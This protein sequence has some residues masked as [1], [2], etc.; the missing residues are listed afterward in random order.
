MYITRVSTVFLCGRRPSD[1]Y[2]GTWW[3]SG[4]TGSQKIQIGIIF[5]WRKKQISRFHFWITK[6][7]ILGIRSVTQ[8]DGRA[9][10]AWKW[11][12]DSLK[13]QWTRK[14]RNCL[15]SWSPRTR[16]GPRWCTSSSATWAL[17]WRSRTPRHLPE[18]GPDRKH[19]VEGKLDI[20]SREEVKKLVSKSIPLLR[21]RGHCR[22]LCW[23]LLQGSSGTLAATQEATAAIS[24]TKTMNSGWK[25]KWPRWEVL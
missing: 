5:G 17:W 10:A 23:P 16:I 20:A 11:A 22:R 9:G 6:K 14:S 19:H 12:G 15:S 24:K 7:I 1:A 25:G 21:A 2:P 13:R 18:K 4:T 8:I 3:H